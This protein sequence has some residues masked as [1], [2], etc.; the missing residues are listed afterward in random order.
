MTVHK[1][2]WPTPHH[3][4]SFS[5]CA[6]SLTHDGQHSFNLGL[7]GYQPKD[8]VQTHREQLRHHLNMLSEPLWL[9]QTHSNIVHHTQQH[10]SMITADACYTNKPNCCTVL[11]ADCLPIPCHTRGTV[12]AIHAGWRG[13]ANGIGSTISQ[14]LAHLTH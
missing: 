13:L 1:P 4:T 9:N 8:V 5:T 2:N 10:Q 11:T 7:Q 3:I 14:L 12:P 6:L